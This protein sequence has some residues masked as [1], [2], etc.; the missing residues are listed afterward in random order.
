MIVLCWLLVGCDRQDQQI[1][2]YRAPKQPP[3]ATQLAAPPLAKS[4]ADAPSAESESPIAWTVPE[5]WEKLPAQQMRFAAFRVSQEHPDVVLTVIP[6]G[7]EAG[8]LLPN[9]NRWRQQLGLP[10]VSQQD[11]D[12]MVRRKQVDGLPVDLVDLSGPATANPPMRM[13][14]AIL[15]HA[16]RVWFFKLVGQADVVSRQQQAFEAF[17]DS[18]HFPGDNRESNSP[19]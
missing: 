18:V 1:R 4:E 16:G 11:L 10:P 2:V 17:I 14:A 6:L 8:E 15:P 5:G 9:V 19:R 7:P 13:L 12:K 3:P